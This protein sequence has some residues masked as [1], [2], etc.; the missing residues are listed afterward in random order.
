MKILGPVRDRHYVRLNHPLDSALIYNVSIILICLVP[1]QH[2]YLWPDLIRIELGYL[3]VLL[4]PHHV[5]RGLLLH[6]GECARYCTLNNV[7]GLQ[8]GV[9]ESTQVPR[10]GLMKGLEISAEDGA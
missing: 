6:S 2:G 4:P 1:L 8:D 3:C 10:W 7:S 9:S 5:E